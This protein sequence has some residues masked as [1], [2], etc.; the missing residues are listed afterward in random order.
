MARLIAV[1]SEVCRGAVG[2][3]VV[4]PAL[5]ALGHDVVAL[6]TV[7]LSNHPG[8]KAV[9]G[10]R[11]DPSTLDAMLD[12]IATNGWL[13]DVAGILT[14][15]LP[16]AGHV[17]FAHRAVEAVRARNP[18]A[19]Y[20]CDPV[21]GDDPKGLYIDPAAAQAIS[22]ELIPH[23][24]LATPNRFELSFLSGRAIAS[25][26]DAAATHLSCPAFVAT[27]IPA[28]AGET[29]NVGRPGGRIGDS[30]HVADHNGA[31]VTTVPLRPH[32]PHGTGDLFSAL[33]FAAL[34][35]G[36]PLTAALAFATAGVDRV[37]AATAPGEDALPLPALPRALGLSWPLR[38]IGK[39]T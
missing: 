2:L 39:T 16:T 10:T 1:S 25:L 12:A 21:L 4:A 29:A 28:T 9:A 38:R 27:S 3:S 15:Y 11:I 30:N 5:R 26:D 31:L 32:A 8:H 24:D 18:D 13:D 17:A 34:A 36:E 35:A 14:G 37:L 7:V 19:L 22:A 20:L 33:L 23:A 6:P